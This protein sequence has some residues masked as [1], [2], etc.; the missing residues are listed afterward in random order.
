MYSYFARQPI[1]NKNNALVGYELLYRK[2]S[3][4]TSFD[5]MVDEDHA[6]ASV[7][8]GFHSTGIAH[9]TGN[10]KGF[11]NFTEK[12][13]LD[14]VA[15]L[16]DNR[17]LVVEVL[18]TI[19]PSEAILNAVDYLR[20]SGYTVALDDFVFEERYL[21]LLKRAD[22]IKI[23]TA[24]INRETMRT[25]L[26]HVDLSRVKLLAEKVE[27]H[28]QLLMAQ[29]FGFTLFQGY[30]FSKPVTMS[31]PAMNPS[32]L[33]Y[34]QIM[35]LVFQPV[36]DF[37]AVSRVIRRDLALSFRIL[38]LVNSPYFGVR[39]K[40]R[41]IHQAVTFLGEGELKKWVSLVALS[42]LGGDRPEELVN[43][44]IIRASVFEGLAVHL[45]LRSER[46]TYFLMGLFSMID[47]IM[48]T[49]MDEILKQLPLE[50]EITDVLV[51]KRGLGYR[52]V[53]LVTANE[54]GEWE[55]VEKIARSIGLTPETVADVIYQ[56]IEWSNSLH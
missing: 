13:L 52:L 23:D 45:G 9:L 53:E 8:D 19:T 4:S 3:A 30:Y 43:M 7:L 54:K 44:S 56:S 26:R 47:S 40:I 21:P 2:D 31:K 28:E 17:H 38:R 24:T 34:I 6:T 12:L 51:N 50:E 35:A 29:S 41:D 32:K 33:N 15:T 46:E 1:M 10:K 20:Q 25:I 11:V 5:S 14:R 36:V 42:G 39:N 18:E 22:I 49:P 27:D 55:T 37:F 16:F 48:A